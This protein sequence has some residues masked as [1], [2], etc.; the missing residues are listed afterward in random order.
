MCTYVT[1]QLFFRRR[2]SQPP[3]A[4]HI[5]PAHRCSFLR[6]FERRFWRGFVCFWECLLLPEGG[7]EDV[8]ITQKRL[9]SKVESWC[10]EW[11]LTALNTVTD[12]FEVYLPLSKIPHTSFPTSCWSNKRILPGFVV[13]LV[14]EITTG[15]RTGTSWGSKNGAQAEKWRSFLLLYGTPHANSRQCGSD[16]QFAR[17]AG[18]VLQRTNAQFFSASAKFKPIFAIKA[19]VSQSFPTSLLPWFLNYD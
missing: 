1:S 10:V 19:V 9:N 16:S 15:T 12:P 4:H 17:S 2:F 18:N 7:G 14:Y 11:F 5:P 13:H 6:Q 3:R 8:D